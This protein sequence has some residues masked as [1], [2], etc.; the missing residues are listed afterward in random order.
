MCGQ[1]VHEMWPAHARH[2]L[3]RQAQPRV[4]ARQFWQAYEP[5]WD[6][7]AWHQGHST[8]GASA[9]RQRG[10]KRNKRAALHPS[11]TNPATHPIEM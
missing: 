4:R 2:A 11:K 8:V 6:T 7:S 9:R 5:Y 1:A 10:S 3:H